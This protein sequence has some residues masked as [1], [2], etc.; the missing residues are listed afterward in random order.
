MDSPPKNALAEGQIPPQKLEVSP[1][2]GLYLL[3]YIYIYIYR[4]KLKLNEDWKFSYVEYDLAWSKFESCV[5]IFWNCQLLLFPV[6]ISN[7]VPGS[8]KFAAKS[9]YHSLQSQLMCTWTPARTEAAFTKTKL[10]ATAEL[11]VIQNDS[12]EVFSSS[13]LV[14]DAPQFLFGWKERKFCLNSITI[15][16]SCDISWLFATGGLLFA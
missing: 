13:S 9:N 11:F 6:I 1:R 16:S 15:Y 7:W 3:V 14:R 8:S 10:K 4:L 12:E 5:V 2:S